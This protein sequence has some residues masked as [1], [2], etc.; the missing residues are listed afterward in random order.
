[1]GGDDALYPHARLDDAMK[2]IANVT[3]GHMLRTLGGKYMIDL[4]MCSHHCADF[5][6]TEF[7]EDD[8]AAIVNAEGLQMLVRLTS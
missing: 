7:L 6:W 5:D 1:V 2:E 3:C 8:R 4:P